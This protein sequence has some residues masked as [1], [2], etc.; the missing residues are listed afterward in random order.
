MEHV[1]QQLNAIIQDLHWHCSQPVLDQPSDCGD[2][3]V[4]DMSR[5]SAAAALADLY[6]L[7]GRVHVQS[8][9]RLVDRGVA[10]LVGGDRLLFRVAASVCG[11]SSLSA[12]DVCYCMLPGRFC[13]LCTRQSGAGVGGAP[14]IHITA[15]LVAAAQSK[16][17]VE[18][19]PPAEL[20]TALFSIT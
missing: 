6:A 15:V 14:C 4:A 3:A 17:S 20:A 7:L 9:M 19:L 12:Q 1:H 5:H 10:C 13:S 18:Q 8:A 2:D 11:G 16:C